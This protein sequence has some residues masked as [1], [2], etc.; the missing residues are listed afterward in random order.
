MFDLNGTGAWQW[1]L[2]VGGTGRK[3]TMGTHIIDDEFW[4]FS[5]LEQSYTNTD[6]ILI[7]GIGSETYVDLGSSSMRGLFGLFQLR[8]P[9]KQFFGL[10]LARTISTRVQ[11]TASNQ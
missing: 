7:R 8:D 5:G 4:Q 1:S 10:R 6:R 11:G 2:T 9:I 3:A